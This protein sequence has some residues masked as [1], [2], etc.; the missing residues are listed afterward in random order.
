MSQVNQHYV[1]QFHFRNFSKDG[2][3]ICALLRGNGKIIPSA[4]FRHQCSRK[5]FYGSQE[6]ERAFSGLEGQHAS[7]I[8]AAL[9]FASEDGPTSFSVE[10]MFRL[11]QAIMF[12]R[13]RTA[14]EIQKSSDAKCAMHL[15]AF[16]HFIEHTEGDNRE[17]ILR[18]I[19]EG[20]V[21]V[22]EN[23]QSNVVESI[24]IFLPMTIGITDLHLCF[25]RNQ[26]DYPFL[27][28]DAPVVFYNTW[29]WNVRNRGVLG[30]QCPGLQIFYPL[31]STVTAMLIDANRYRGPWS[32]QVVLDLHRRADVSQL[33]A[34][35]IHHAMSTVYF[36]K[37]ENAQYVH[38]LWSAHQ[39]QL[40]KLQ[41][42]YTDKSEFWID[43]K[44]PEGDLM[45]MFEPQVNHPLSLSFVDCDPILEHEYEYGPR[46]PEIDEELKNRDPVGDAIDAKQAAI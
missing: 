35:Q 20:K 17:E 30:I 1:P 36:A 8:R 44:P 34:L 43:G 7:A 32:D 37:S 41:S 2:K 13:G 14:L 46:D 4:P 42:I 3:H 23:P 25:L 39:P 21:S 24:G 40:E 28:S 16:R 26:T 27:F 31:S 19:D 38:D 33:N 11:L 15:T 5:N 9:K 29:G 45:H 10:N 22:S 12:Q 6:L 18:A